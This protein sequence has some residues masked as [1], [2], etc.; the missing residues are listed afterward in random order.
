MPW[1]YQITK[2]DHSYTAVKGQLQHWVVALHLC[3]AVTGNQE[4]QP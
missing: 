3:E 1:N 2:R 4:G